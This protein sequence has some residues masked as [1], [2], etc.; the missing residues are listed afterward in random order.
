MPREVAGRE[1]EFTKEYEET[2]WSDS[3]VPHL[4]VVMVS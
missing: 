1:G 3:Y 2:F 4:I